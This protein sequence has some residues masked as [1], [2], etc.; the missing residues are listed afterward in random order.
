MEHRCPQASVPSPSNNAFDEEAENAHTN[1]LSDELQDYIQLVV[2][3][4]SRLSQ[5]SV[6][7]VRLIRSYL[8]EGDGT[9]TH[10]VGPIRTNSVMREQGFDVL[11]FALSSQFPLQ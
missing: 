2:S 9:G 5:I 8:P 4:G 6:S 10:L 3:S 7:S 1:T 11:N